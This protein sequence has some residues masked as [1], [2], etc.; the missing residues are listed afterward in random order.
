M[1]VSLPEKNIDTNGELIVQLLNVCK[2]D[3]D[4]EPDVNWP[5]STTANGRRGLSGTG[6]GYVTVYAI[7]G[8]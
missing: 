7:F 2:L 1:T 4:Q 8:G 3:G 5:Y 6:P